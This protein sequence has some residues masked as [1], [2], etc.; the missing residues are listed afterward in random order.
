MHRIHL[1]ELEDQSWCP[2]PIRDGITD[3]LQFAFKAGKL[4]DKML[5]RLIKLIQKTGS[6]R[7]ID[8]C[9]GAGG[10]WPT[11]TRALD[12]HGLRY[13]TVCLTDK[14]PSLTA[15]D[16]AQRASSDRIEYRADTV[17]ARDVPDDLEGVRTM[18]TSFHHFDQADALAILRNAVE[19][20]QGIAVVEVT[21]R[22]PLAIL[23]MFL[24]PLLVALATPMIRPY[25][26]SRL[27]WTYL[28]PLIPLAVMFDGIVS[29]LR[30]YSLDE[31]KVLTNGLVTDGSY[32]WEMG[33]ERFGKLPIGLT[34]LIGYPVI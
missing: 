15:M 5:P 29:C 22:H 25:R 19:D 6:S 32:E 24:T 31:I 33:I 14:F 12:N 26:W 30:T 9:S 8:L 18:F 11:L 10:P 23:Y 27:F 21:Q 4:Y 28:I 16:N 34:Y 17:D 7:I 2:R 1:L 20:R 3:Y 13:V